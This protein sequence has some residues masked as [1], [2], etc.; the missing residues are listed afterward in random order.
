MQSRPG[1]LLVG[2]RN[3]GVFSIAW[4]AHQRGLGVVVRLTEARARK[5][6]GGTDP[7]GRRAD[8]NLDGEPLRRAATRGYA[9]GGVAARTPD[10]GAHRPGQV[11]G[12]ALPVHHG[13]AVAGKQLLALYGKRW[14]IETDLRSLKRTVRLHH[15]AARNESM[16][17]KELLTAVAAY[18][19]VRAVMALAARR[20]HLSPR[21]LSFTFVLN[22]V[23]ARWHRLQAAPDREAYQ[24]EVFGL[25]DAAAE[26]VHP[27]RNTRRSF[28]RA[29]WHR[30]HT[31]PARKEAPM[32]YLSGIG[33]KRLS[34]TGSIITG[35]TERK[36][37]STAFT[38][39]V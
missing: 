31:F 24:R 30:R 32:S 25:L 15:V 19:L 6:V 16:M 23:N 5:L 9:G 13:G 7:R 38:A 4:A 35:R 20:H 18:N 36:G 21:Q 17:E 37:G 3:F 8:G 22:V 26:G 28:P 12:M 29:A 10:C 11:Q 34:T 1:S 14:R 33:R 39:V 2:D 27:K